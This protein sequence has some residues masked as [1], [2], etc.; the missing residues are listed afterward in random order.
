MRSVSIDQ[1]TIDR[2]M[3]GDNEA[4]GMLVRANGS[5]SLIVAERI[6]RSPE[7]AVS[8]ARKLFVFTYTNL[9]KLKDLGVLEMWLMQ[10]LVRVCGEVLKEATKKGVALSQCEFPKDLATAGLLES[11]GAIDTAAGAPGALAAGAATS[12]AATAPVAAARREAVRKAIDCLPFLERTAVIFRDWDGMSYLEVADILRVKHDDVRKLLVR[13]RR[14]VAEMLKPTVSETNCGRVR[15]KIWLLAGGEVGPT[16]TVDILTHLRQCS[17]CA[18]SLRTASTVVEAIRDAAAPED[19]PLIAPEM[20]WKE[21][22]PLLV[23]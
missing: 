2:A 1:N 14:G 23:R 12:R 22:E 15:D 4:F 21:V 7:E 16:E 5:R 20:L 9:K 17:A 6:L 18:E 3:E 8:A 10:N 19:K 13:G 11:V